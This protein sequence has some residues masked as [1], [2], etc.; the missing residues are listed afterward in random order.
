MAQLVEH[1]TLDQDS[2]LD[3]R[4]ISSGPTLVSMLDVEATLKKTKVKSRESSFF[5]SATQCA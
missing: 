3:L 1:L 2:G 5:Y 4:V